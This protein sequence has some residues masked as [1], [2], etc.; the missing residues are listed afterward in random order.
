MIITADT[1]QATIKIQGLLFSAP[2]PFV[3]GYAL[4][5]SEAAALNQLLHENL[6][7]NFAGRVKE[8][9]KARNE[10]SAQLNMAE[11][12][13]AFSNYA[14]GY[15]FGARRTRPTTAPTA[16]E[17]RKIAADLVREALKAKGLKVKELP[18]GKFAELVEQ[19]A[20]RDEVITAAQ[21]RIEERQQ[22]SG[23]VA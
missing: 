23:I 11:L 1:P 17:A 15:A 8:A 20:K 14:M 7:G 19:A 4:T 6:R 22:L 16:N 10:D 2:S 12:Q 13:A 9:L 3:E 5:K 21:R 18:E